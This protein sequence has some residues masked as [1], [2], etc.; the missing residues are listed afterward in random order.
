MSS[1]IVLLGAGTFSQGDV[2]HGHLSAP[3]TAALA[4][5]NHLGTTTQHNK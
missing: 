1:Q 5:Q 3:A 2:I 4:L